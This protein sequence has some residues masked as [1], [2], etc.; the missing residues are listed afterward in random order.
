MRFIAAQYLALLH[1]GLWLRSAAQ[2]NRM[3]QLLAGELAGL[4][5][6]TVTHPVQ[7]NEVFVIFPAEI[8]PRVQKRWPFHIWNES[9]SEAR[10]IT[11]FDTEESDVQD[12]AELVR[13][14]LG[15]KEKQWI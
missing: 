3:A 11:S 13:E 14:A 7:A 8:V 15:S 4:K 10:L 5:G 12:F 2:A 1:D 6:V 9:L